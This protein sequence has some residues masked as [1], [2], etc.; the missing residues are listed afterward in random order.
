MAD[1]PWVEYARMQTELRERQEASNWSWGLEAGLSYI[2][3]DEK[4]STP[5]ANDDID[6]VVSNSQR[7]ER[8]RMAL[9]R[10]H[11]V[12]EEPTSN[13]LASLEVREELRAVRARMT[14]A[15]WDLLCAVGAGWTYAE[16]VAAKGGT[17][18]GLRVRILR[19]RRG[20]VA[21]NLA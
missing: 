5:P 17:P 3:S 4:P 9:R 16:I 7:Q 21:K 1:I 18:G 15:D 10:L 13:P 2:L 11:L 12:H 6:R 14:K 20:A 8:H 19:L